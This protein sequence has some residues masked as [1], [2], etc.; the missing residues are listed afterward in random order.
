MRKAGW[1]LPP[2]LLTRSA[3]HCIYISWF[4]TCFFWI[5]YIH[6]GLFT[7]L[8][9][10]LLISFLSSG[11]FPQ[12][13]AIPNARISFWQ[14]WQL[15]LPAHIVGCKPLWNDQWN[16]PSHDICSANISWK[17]LS[18]KHTRDFGISG[19]KMWNL[20]YFFKGNYWQVSSI[21]NKGKYKYFATGTQPRMSLLLFLW[22]C[23]SGI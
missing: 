9:S 22:S 17:L 16:I 20:I 12:S 8:I 15:S 6:S 3:Q 19:V 14:N 13:T 23:E 5:S 11:S 18:N 21:W 2:W 1:G 4:S 7:L 10:R